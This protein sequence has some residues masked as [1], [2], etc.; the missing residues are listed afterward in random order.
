MRRVVAIATISALLVA[1]IAITSF[2][3]VKVIAER[4]DS[5]DRVL[6][7]AAEIEIQ[8]E[9]QRFLQMIVEDQRFK[10]RLL[11]E[12]WEKSEDSLFALLS[13]RDEMS[14]DLSELET[15]REILTDTLQDIHGK[16]DE[17]K[18]LQEER[19]K[20]TTDL[21]AKQMTLPTHADPS[22]LSEPGNCPSGDF[23]GN[24]S[25]YS[26][27]PSQTDSDPLISATGPVHW[28]TVAV[29]PNVIPY[30][31]RIKIEGFPETMIFVAEDTG[32]AILGYG[33]R[34]D[35]WFPW[36]E[37]TV[38]ELWGRRLVTVTVL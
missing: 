22:H 14:E 9:A 18:S 28:G 33:N 27:T 4:E 5:Q 37:E 21:V 15:R 10:L 20:S 38:N 34:I 29:D 13:R 7:L 31:C 19:D 16:Q 12:D 2:F 6:A 32:S 35:I 30:G 24:V 25:G 23:T 8:Q 26:S 11:Y 3:M 36:S 1:A 17:L